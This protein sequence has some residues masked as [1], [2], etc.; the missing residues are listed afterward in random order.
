MVLVIA[1][2][3]LH[4]LLDSYYVRR[5]ERRVRLRFPRSGSMKIESPSGNDVDAAVAAILRDIPPLG[6]ETR[7]AS[8]CSRKS[9]N[10][11]GFG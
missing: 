9:L 3:D 10:Q 4:Q 7:Y 11:L 6:R 1:H 2:D 8:L 5:A